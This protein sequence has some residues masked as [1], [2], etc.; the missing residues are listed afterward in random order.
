MRVMKFISVAVGVA[1]LLTLAIAQ[2]AATAP[3]TP[4]VKHVPI[5]RAPVNSGKDMF[6]SYCAVC[7]GTDAKGG[8][9]A[10]SAMKTNPV[11]LTTL[12]KK[13]GGKY[14]AAHVAAVLRGQAITASHGSQDM[15]I[16]GPLFS[17]ISQGHEAQ[18][19][20][21]IANLVDYVETLQA[22]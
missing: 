5:N 19:Q 2:Q 11:D 18:V 14:P 16:W 8:G 12:A 17:S 4:T 9:P 10:A 1:M 22:K 15:P 7:H 13:S 20:Q 6:N 3:S 21:R